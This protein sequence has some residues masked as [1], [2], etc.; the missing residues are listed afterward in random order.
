VHVEGVRCR[1]VQAAVPTQAGDEE[2]AAAGAQKDLLVGLVGVQAD[3]RQQQRRANVQV[4]VEGR[5]GVLLRHGRAQV[6]QVLGGHRR[7]GEGGSRSD[8]IAPLTLT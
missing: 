1:H 4:A 8:A 3:G 7:R 5:G 6:D 2:H